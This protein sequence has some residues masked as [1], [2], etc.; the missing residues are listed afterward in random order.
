[1]ERNRSCQNPRGT[2]ASIQPET[3]SIRALPTTHRRVR[4][5]KSFED[6]LKSANIGMALAFVEKSSW[7]STFNVQWA[8]ASAIFTLRGI[9]TLGMVNMMLT[10][11]CTSGY[12]F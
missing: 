2:S 10:L 12:F 1:M 7:G 9:M 5:S 6:D 8:G 3:T 11:T 4:G